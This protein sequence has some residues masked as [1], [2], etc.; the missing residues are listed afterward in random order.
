MGK[1]KEY[2]IELAKLK[3]LLEYQRGECRQR[4]LKRLYNVWFWYTKST[5]ET[6]RCLI[7]DFIL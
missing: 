1:K 7:F 3:K 6:R 2:D 5:G 4:Q